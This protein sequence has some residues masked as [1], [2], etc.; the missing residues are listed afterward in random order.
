M[1]Q[2]KIWKARVLQLARITLLMFVLAQAE[3]L[4]LQAQSMPQEAPPSME[5]K[6][7][8]L[9]LPETD[10]YKAI[11]QIIEETAQEAAEDA[12]QAGYDYG[13][14]ERLRTE[15]QKQKALEKSRALWR[16]AAV[17]EAGAICTALA[18]AW[19]VKQ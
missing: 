3:R 4:P 14:Q 17:I 7:L 13:I 19:Y 6:N 1:K 12:Y 11:E 15:Q 16:K 8:R 18:A 2:K 10:L 5:N 9:L